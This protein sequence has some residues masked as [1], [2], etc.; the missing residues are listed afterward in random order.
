MHSL[1][2]PVDATSNI[3]VKQLVN[4]G[5]SEEDILSHLWQYSYDKFVLIIVKFQ[6]SSMNILILQL[7]LTN[8]VRVRNFLANNVYFYTLIYLAIEDWRNA[9]SSIIISTKILPNN[10]GSP[11]PHQVFD[12]R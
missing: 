2:K 8:L 9:L 6:V 3:T 1:E 10:F 11:V 7:D 5:K 12:Y 4:M